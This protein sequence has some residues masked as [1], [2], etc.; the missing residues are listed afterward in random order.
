MK[1]PP[2][3]K[4]PSS[5][6]LTLLPIREE[7]KSVHFFNGLAQVGL[8]DCFF[9]PHLHSTILAQIGFPEVPDDLF[10][11]YTDLI[12][13]HSQNLEEDQREITQRAVEIYHMLMQ[14]KRR[15]WGEPD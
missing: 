1:N 3:V 13:R 12:D 6:D 9:H 15:R 5:L 10:V 4:L 14:E 8:N 2:L 11:F 7:V